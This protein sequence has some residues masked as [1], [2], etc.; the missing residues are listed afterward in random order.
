MIP[1]RAANATLFCLLTAG[2]GGAAPQPKLQAENMPTLTASA[3]LG[4]GLASGP[5]AASEALLWE[6]LPKDPPS[7]IAVDFA[8]LTRS[9]FGNLVQALRVV[10]SAKL[11]KCKV[12]P[13]DS[14]GR[15]LIAFTNYD[16]RP[17]GIA[18]ETT[19]PARDVLACLA[20]LSGATVE[21]IY[22]DKLIN[23]TGQLA[24]DPFVVVAAGPNLLLG[25]PKSQL[26]AR[27][28]M[29]N[30][31]VPVLSE[32]NLVYGFGA[33]SAFGDLPIERAELAIIAKPDLSEL[34][35]RVSTNKPV[36][37]AEDVKQLPRALDLLKIPSNLAA[38]FQ[39]RETRP[40]RE[41]LATFSVA[42][43]DAAQ[44]KQIG[45]VV[46]FGV[47]GVREYISH[48]KSAEAK[49]TVFL[50]ATNAKFAFDDSLVRSKAGNLSKRPTCGLVAPLTPAVAPRGVKH[51]SSPADWAVP[52]WKALDFAMTDP[53][54]YAYGIERSADGQVCIFYAVGDLNGDGN[55]S[56]FSLEA[57]VTKDAKGM[58]S[59]TVARDIVEVNP[60]E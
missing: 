60:L 6:H 31:H 12:S 48:A 7:F 8:G 35:L 52:G 21:S 37:V 53:Q 38:L 39:V 45:D 22:W 5:A 14:I 26:A 4:A 19:T 58:P 54:Y 24:Q 49:R 32:T 43:N 2:C 41:F 30:T 11:D 56:R 17:D 25:A 57:R 36:P 9:P 16:K 28:R 34:S 51:Q 42:G 3:T 29:A 15:V 55:T 23:P 27:L 13:F 33:A 40:Q 59:L 1:T 18:I 50:L 47:N 20:T 46:A 44:H 10:A